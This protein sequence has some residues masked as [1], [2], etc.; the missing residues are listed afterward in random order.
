MRDVIYD[1]YVQEESDGT[2][3]MLHRG[4]CSMTTLQLSPDE[5]FV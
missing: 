4:K 3:T 5:S 1:Y 2:F